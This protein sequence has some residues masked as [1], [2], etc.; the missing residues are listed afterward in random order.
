MFTH[1]TTEACPSRREHRAIRPVQ[2]E[3]RTH[4]RRRYARRR[5]TVDPRAIPACRRLARTRRGGTRG[6]SHG[7]G[8]RRSARPGCRPGTGADLAT[9]DTPRDASLHLRG[10]L[11]ACGRMDGRNDGSAWEPAGRLA[12]G[13]PNGRPRRHMVRRERPDHP[14]SWLPPLVPGRTSGGGSQAQLHPS[15]GIRGASVDSTPPYQPVRSSWRSGRRHLRHQ[16]AAPGAAPHDIAAARGDAPRSVRLSSG[17]TTPGGAVVP[18]I[19]AGSHAVTAPPAGS[20]RRPPRTL[21]CR[22]RPV[23]LDRRWR[24]SNC[25]EVQAAASGAVRHRSSSPPSLAGG[26]AGGWGSKGADGGLTLD[27]AGMGA[28]GGRSMQPT[29]SWR[30]GE[31]MGHWRRTASV[32][33]FEKRQFDTRFGVGTG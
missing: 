26:S 11:R 23:S 33:R 1:R 6:P 5:P 24:A 29:E 7:G 9:P 8:S 20:D 19:R 12:D 10:Q 28:V 31:D 2:A 32:I 25:R 13:R 22:F 18:G 16:A 3:N 17:T 21:R 4:R 14:R 30:V 15:P 27:L